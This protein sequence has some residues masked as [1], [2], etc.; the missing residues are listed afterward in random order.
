M[1]V[2]KQT[3][4]QIDVVWKTISV[5]MIAIL[6][7]LGVLFRMTM[8]MMKVIENYCSDMV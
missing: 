5:N 4:I 6:N 8:V 7:P 3:A 1:P 2:L